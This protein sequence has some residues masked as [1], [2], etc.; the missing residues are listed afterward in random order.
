MTLSSPA[1]PLTV[2]NSPYNAD[3][4]VNNAFALP[5]GAGF[6][7]ATAYQA[8]RTAQFQFRFSF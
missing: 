7:V 8:A 5:R 4:S 1:D 2:L 6:G 3:G